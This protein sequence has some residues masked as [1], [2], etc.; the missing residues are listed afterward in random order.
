MMLVSQ[1]RARYR[2]PFPPMAA[3]RRPAAA[4]PPRRPVN[5]NFYHPYY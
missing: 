1:N 3:G 4:Y 5:P 2:A